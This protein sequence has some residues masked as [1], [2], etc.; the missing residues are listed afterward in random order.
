MDNNASGVILY[1]EKDDEFILV[2]EVVGFENEHH[3]KARTEM[4]MRVF[5]HGS[6]CDYTSWIFVG[7]I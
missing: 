7:F 5:K 2:Y 6:W 4:M 1:S 3:I